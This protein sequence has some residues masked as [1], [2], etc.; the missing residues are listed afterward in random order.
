MEP[1]AKQLPTHYPRITYS[2]P[3]E[4]LR[5]T[6]AEGDFKSTLG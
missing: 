4:D 1:H 6:Y 3:I 2:Q 5:Q